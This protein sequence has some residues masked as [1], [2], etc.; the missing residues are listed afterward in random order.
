MKKFSLALLAAATAFAFIP[1][2]SAS[3]ITGTI[4]INGSNDTWTA[5]Q[6]VFAPTPVAT[7]AGSPTTSGT[8][9]AVIGDN[10]SFPTNPLV[11]S[12]ADGKEFFSTGDGVTFTITSLTVD[13]DNSVALVLNG[14]GTITENGYSSTTAAWSLSSTDTGSTTFGINAAPSATPEP[15][16]L[17][18]LGTGLFG[19]A[20]VAFR[21]AKSSGGLVLRP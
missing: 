9:A 1:S 11:F 2:A 19:L 18:L 21:K 12:T 10:V 16:S 17:I 13:F 8:L 4:G 7:V 3:P 15:S 20:F 14:L 6:L 5:T